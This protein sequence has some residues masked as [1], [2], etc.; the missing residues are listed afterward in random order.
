[1]RVSYYFLNILVSKN[2]INC[3]TLFNNL[4][5]LSGDVLNINILI[6]KNIN[7]NTGWGAYVFLIT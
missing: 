4:D 5:N 6:Q 7:I 1:M 2:I 3:H